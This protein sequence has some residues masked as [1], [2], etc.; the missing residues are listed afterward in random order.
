[1]IASMIWTKCRTM[2]SAGSDQLAV[3]TADEAGPAD[4][5]TRGLAGQRSGHAARRQGQVTAARTP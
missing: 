5:P 1:M 2:A 3:G 4:P